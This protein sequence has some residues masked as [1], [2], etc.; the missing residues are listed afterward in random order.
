MKP[1]LL[2]T[3][4]LTTGLA[5][6]T[7]AHEKGDRCEDDHRDD[8]SSRNRKEE[9]MNCSRSDDRRYREDHRARRSRRDCDELP[10]IIYSEPNYRY[11]YFPLLPP[12]NYH[13]RFVPIPIPR[14]PV[15]LLPG[16]P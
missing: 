10:I 6:T 7:L 15:Y 8:R 2:T 5:V 1:S 3:L 4:L 9:R 11:G 14:R 16:M 13:G 12:W